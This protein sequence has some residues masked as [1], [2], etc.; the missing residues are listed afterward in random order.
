[1]ALFSEKT[2]AKALAKPKKSLGAESHLAARI[3]TRPRVT[4]KSYALG[5]LNQYV[6]VV[7]RDA[8]KPAVKQ[9]IEEA[10]GVQVEKIRMVRLPAKK[11]A[12]G[13]QGRRSGSKGSIKKAIVSVAQ[14]QSIELLKSGM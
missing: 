13:R 11:K 7:K 10:Y 9:A 4:E 2:Q 14:G 6:F 12:T 8:T 5:T 3:L 1:M